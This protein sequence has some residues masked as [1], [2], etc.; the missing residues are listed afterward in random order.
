VEIRANTRDL[1]AALKVTTNTFTTSGTDISSHYIFRVVEDDDGAQKLEVLSHKQP[2]RIYSSCP[3]VSEIEC[4]DGEDT[5]FTIEAKRFDYLISNVKDTVLTFKINAG[6]VTV[7][8]PSP[9]GKLEFQSLDPSTF[10]YWDEVLSK[11]KLV[12]EIAANHLAEVFGFAKMFVSDQESRN[13]GMCVT[14]A[15]KGMLLSTNMV[16]VTTIRADLL[17]KSGMRV[18][19]KDI[20]PLLKYLAASDRS[21][22][23]V[24]EDDRNV[25]FQRADGA[26]FGAGRFNSAF[27]KLALPAEGADDHHWWV[28]PKGR[29][30]DALAFLKAAVKKDDTKLHMDRRGDNMRLAVDCVTGNQ[31]DILIPLSDSGSGDD[32]PDIPSGGFTVDRKM[33]ESVL[34][35]T[36]LEEVR[37][38][39]CVTPKG[40]FVRILETRE[41]GEY[42]MISTWIV[43]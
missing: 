28:V 18:H 16:T 14:E 41:S 15:R 1:E 32:A 9:W 22:I 7:E 26:L 11:A 12:G 6:V 25:F 20:A 30:L 31:G 4:K 3:C 40:G 10:I 42:R 38:G 35:Q 27:P 36:D 34:S 43:G 39:L 17:A 23:K 21:L 33:M 13:P 24:L 29:V 5:S 37:F 19:N 2:G 8:A